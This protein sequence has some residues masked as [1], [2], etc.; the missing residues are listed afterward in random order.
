MKKRQTKGQD[1]IQRSVVTDRE[2]WFEAKAKAS[3]QGVNMSAVVVDLLRAWL[4]NDIEV[5]EDIARSK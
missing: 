1:M 4:R 3:R 5:S 2:T